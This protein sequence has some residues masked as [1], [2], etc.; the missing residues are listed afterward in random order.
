MAR[1]DPGSRDADPGLYRVSH[2]ENDGFHI[3]AAV[4]W[5]AVE[6]QFRTALD[7]VGWYAPAVWTE[8]QW[9]QRQ[10]ALAHGGKALA[11]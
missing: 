8:R 3:G 11:S 5:A 2:W 4:T 6:G 10:A 7:V 9:Q 1:H